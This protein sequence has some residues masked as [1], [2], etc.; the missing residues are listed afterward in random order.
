[1]KTKIKTYG[2]KVYTNFC[3]LNVPHVDIKSESFTIISIDSS[4]IYE[5]KYYLQ[6]YLDNCAY[7]IVD[8]KN[9]RLSW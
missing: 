2:D 1:M 7:K 8:K 9:D 4:L 6:V 3:A 5:S